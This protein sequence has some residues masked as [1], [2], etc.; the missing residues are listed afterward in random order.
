[1]PPSSG[2][3]F[4]K[5]ASPRN[6]STIGLAEF[7]PGTDCLRR[8]HELQSR[9]LTGPASRGIITASDRLIGHWRL[10]AYT[11]VKPS[12]E[13]IDVFG[14]HPK[15]YLTYSSDRRMT[16]VVGG[17]ERPRLSGAWQAVPAAAKA[18]NYDKL[19]AYAGRYTDLG[20]K[21]IHH[22]EVC[23]IPNWEG[24]DLERLVVPAGEGRMILRTPA[25]RPP[26]QDL[27]WERVR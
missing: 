17:D 4:F 3:S 25:D 15:G 23:W 27:L 22:V 14:P 20:D 16:V 9:H 18:A 11:E 24:R 13:R 26:S 5:P 19:I 1:M 10:V 12:G 2:T 7:A 21:V 6:K 8:R